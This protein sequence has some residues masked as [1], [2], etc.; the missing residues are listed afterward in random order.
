MDISYA[1][2]SGNAIVE[3][4]F[5][6]EDSI[7]VGFRDPDYAF[8]Y[9]PVWFTEIGD[10][11]EISATLIDENFLVSGYWPGWQDSG[12]AGKPI[13]IHASLDPGQITL[14]GL[15]ITFRGHPENTFRLLGNAIFT[16]IDYDH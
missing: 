12:A 6:P 2:N 15:D 9:T 3:V 10:G 5:D 4:A 14:I 11:V 16:G 13:V 7:S 1:S 8:V